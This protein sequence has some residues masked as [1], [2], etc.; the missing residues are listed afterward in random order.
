MDKHDEAVK[1]VDTLDI[2]KNLAIGR[3][4]SVLE[5]KIK[6]KKENRRISISTIL[7]LALLILVL[8]VLFVDPNVF[9]RTLPELLRELWKY[10]SN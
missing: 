1:F 9:D 8:W 5:K 6:N 2:A 7:L 3:G 4:A 10:L